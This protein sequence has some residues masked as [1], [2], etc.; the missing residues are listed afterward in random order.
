MMCVD[1]VVEILIA[2]HLHV[3]PAQI[4]AAQQPQRAMA[5]CVAI[6]R[7]LA[8]YA[9]QRRGKRLPKES[10]CG[11][12]ATV[13]SKQEVDGLALLVHG[14]IQVVPL[15][16]DRNVGLVHSP[17][18]ADRLREPSPSLFELGDV[19]GYPS[20]DRTVAVSYT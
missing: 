6:K 11:R 7:D 9:R 20:E 19:A 10:L 1:E 8:R 3:P 12:D 15:R 17:R 13:T 14:S 18:G 5:R 2:P 4:F 16:L